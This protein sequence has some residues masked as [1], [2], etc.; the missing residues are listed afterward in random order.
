[1]RRREG[2]TRAVVVA[3]VLVLVAACSGDDAPSADPAPSTEPAS[4]APPTTAVVAPSTT[5]AADGP[6]STRPGV[7]Q[8]AVVDAPPGAEI[9]IVNAS[10][11]IAA[12]G[13]TDEQGSYLARQL[14]PGD[15][16]VTTTGEPLLVSGVVSVHPP[17]AVPDPALYTEQTL[18]T[19]FGYITT[20]DGTTLSANVVLPGPVE[21]G[22]YPTVVEYSGYSPSNP[23]GNLFATLFT[24]L[25]YAYV[26]VNMRGTGCSG[27]S[28]RFFETPQ[29]ADGYDV[30]ETVAAQPWV[31]GHRVG[32]V[33]VSFPGI[34][35][36]FVA[37]TQPPSLA[38]ITPLSV[39]DDSYRST[40]YPGGILN[41]GF[42]VSWLT[43]R[44]EEARPFGQAWTKQRADG[45]DETC[46]ANQNLR[47]Q[48]PDML[49]EVR[50]NPFYEDTL[51]DAIAPST[52]V[53]RINVPVFLAGAWQD[54]Q[55]GG[56]FPAMLDDFTG[57]PHVYA[58]LM[59]GLHTE[60]IGPSS[61][62]RLVEFL[63]L[64]VAQRVPSLG[65][66]RMIA[67]VLAAGIYGTDQVALPPDRFQGMTY[68]A[69]LATFEADPPIQIVFEEGAADGA[70]P[71]AP[72]GRFTRGFDAW[73]I[74]EA[75]TTT[76]RLHGGEDGT[77][78]LGE[79]S[80]PN[81][82][83]PAATYTADPT[84]LPET[85]FAGSGNDIWRHD[86]TYDWRAI[87]DGTGLTYTSA[88]LPTD[89]V[90]AGSGSA[91]LWISSSAADT[92][93]E[94]TVSEV[95]ADGTIVYVQS[96][97]LRASQR[98]LDSA[99]STPTRPVHTQLE[100]D[101]AS[102]P[103]DGSVVPVRVQ[104]F[105]FAHAFRAGSSLRVTIDAPGNARP[106]W[107]FES[108]SAGEQVTV[109]TTPEFPSAVVLDVIPGVEVPAGYPACGSLRGQPC[110]PA[111]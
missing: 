14:V 4:S 55:T 24:T 54:E 97:W 109:H 69:A 57:S 46:A 106:V 20:R 28:W 39:L 70:Q 47:L 38:A 9:E 36:L 13:I 100:A 85:F 62:P 22:P 37:A 40:L 52:F 21:N 87:P 48:N 30:I 80:P 95:R 104:I 61:F 105:P 2:R 73:P 43:E 79:C 111:P 102:L 32:M 83:S 44:V 5:V 98:A 34:S 89:T 42:A 67:P 18:S 60:S 23:D 29:N 78:V 64:Y 103:T 31:A 101:A 107:A 75:V 82:C 56:H 8:I 45:G 68:D 33:G 7:N 66:A 26:G 71:G 1:M 17:E 49:A 11:D 15:Y 10:G 41:T 91:D 16:Q 65:A 96:G 84:A 50:A 53:D 25:G 76:W 19:G 77:G 108:V 88:P 81:A 90:I 58:T 93:L 59:N 99:A 12:K 35:Q 6:L 92:D 110:R 3:A 63:D 86:T 94:V 51:G 74:P 72:M 27:G